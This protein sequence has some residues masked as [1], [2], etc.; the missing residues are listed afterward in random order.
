MITL[1]LTEAEVAVVSDAL[2]DVDVELFA[3][4]EE[5][6]YEAAIESVEAKIEEASS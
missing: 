5:D 3:Q 1:E 4:G 6:E 2:A